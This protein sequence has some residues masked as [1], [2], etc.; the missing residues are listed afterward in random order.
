MATTTTTTKKMT[1]R[2]MFEQIKGKYP[3]TAEE[4]AFIDHEIELLTKKNS[5]DKKPTAK[6]EANATIK[7][8]IQTVMEAHP[9]QLFTVS[10]LMKKVPNLPEDMSN[11]RMSAL[12]RQMVEA[13]L[14][15]RTE[16]QRKAYFSL[17]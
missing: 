11:Q 1:K 16:V 7:S 8:A 6:Q 2:E 4:V 17:A 12:I 9:N 14:V 3:L 10:E 15:K 13:G 5:A